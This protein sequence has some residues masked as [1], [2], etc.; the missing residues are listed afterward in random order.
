MYV[1]P[2][3]H[4]TPSGR[5]N[6]R[7]LGRYRLLEPLQET[8][9][10][11]LY[12]A[13]CTDTKEPVAVKILHTHHVTDE[14][15]LLRFLHEI[16]VLSRLDHPNIVRYVD[17]LVPEEHT[18]PLYGLVMEFLDGIDLATVL[19]GPRLPW[20]RV[21][22]IAMQL[23]DALEAVHAAE[24]LHRDVKPENIL[25]ITWPDKLFVKLLDFGIAKLLT[26]PS[27]DPVPR[28][29]TSAH[30]LMGTPRYVPPERIRKESLGYYTDIYGL[31]IVMYE[32]LCGSDVFET[33]ATFTPA[34]IH[35]MPL[36]PPRQAVPAIELSEAAE[37]VIMKA[38][39]PF[40]NMRFQTMAELRQAIGSCPAW[41]A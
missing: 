21:R 22:T 34:Q 10:S 2:V 35:A 18:E 9:M 36:V 16:E 41:S 26:D 30:K 28:P 12:R 29:Q 33:D 27:R 39:A 14:V 31:G 11:M 40:P 38:T 8:D 13:A 15:L 24:I 1:R 7:V 3:Q 6:G 23:C 20:S 25:L 17:R 37:Q 5:L 4:H 19:E 32:M